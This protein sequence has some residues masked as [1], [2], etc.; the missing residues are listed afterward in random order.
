MQRKKIFVVVC[1]STL[2]A[3]AVRGQNILADGGKRIPLGLEWRAVAPVFWKVRNPGTLSLEKPAVSQALPLM[4]IPANRVV[5]Q[6]GFF[7][8]KE[9]QLEKTIHLPLHFRLGDLQYCNKMEG[10]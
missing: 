1:I 6:F 8:R 5:N 10:K 3:G 2:L 7:C 9:L 4:S